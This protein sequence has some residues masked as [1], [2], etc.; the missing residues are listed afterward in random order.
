MSLDPRNFRRAL[1]K[2][3]TGVT[4]VTTVDSQGQR[5]GVTA[6]SFNSV[7]IDPPLVL[8]SVDKSAYSA[9]VFRNA[10]HFVINVL[11]NDQVDI[12]NRFARRGEEKFEGVACSEGVGNAPRI[13]GAVAC[14]ECR[15]WNVYEGGDHHIIVGEVLDFHYDESRNSLVFHNGRYA[16]PQQHPVTRE[17]DESRALDGVL[18]ESLIYL[19]RQAYSACCDGL[20]PKLG[21]Y[22]VTA[23]EWRVLTLLSDRGPMKVDDIGAVVMQP[24]KGMRDTL[25]WLSEKGFVHVDSDDVVTLTDAGNKITHRLL[26][27]AREFESNALGALSADQTG[28]LKQQLRDI[29]RS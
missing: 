21:D 14:F 23:Q 28:L 29:A 9:E 26:D 1:G 6:S 19:L 4:V 18:G 10:P 2:F 17:V 8:W 25:A 11:A 5:I 16:I 20:Y 15:T 12:S 22:G 7:S 3:A 24:P 13:A 27:M